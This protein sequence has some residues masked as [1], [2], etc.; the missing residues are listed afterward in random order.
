[1]T[2]SLQSHP[3]EKGQQAAGPLTIRVLRETGKSEMNTYICSGASHG[4]DTRERVS[5]MCGIS[6]IHT[7][8]PF[9]SLPCC[10]LEEI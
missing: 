3:L 10:L 6:I 5:S 9:S 1:M 2:C 4:T 7:S 8:K